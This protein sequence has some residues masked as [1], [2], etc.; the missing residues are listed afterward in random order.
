MQRRPSTAVL[1]DAG[2]AQAQKA[3]QENWQLACLQRRKEGVFFKP[4]NSSCTLKCWDAATATSLC[5]KGLD[6]CPAPGW[7]MHPKRFVVCSSGIVTGVLLWVFLFGLLLV[8]FFSGGP[9]RRAMRTEIYR[10]RG[11]RYLYLEEMVDWVEHYVLS[12]H[13]LSSANSGCSDP[14]ATF[15]K[16][17]GN[18][19]QSRFLVHRLLFLLI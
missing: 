2:I 4:S 17:I 13:Q 16:G 3:F 10:L 6:T 12:R 1:L 5:H 8:F 7:G 9:F 15:Q 18:W 11:N 19:N 14:F